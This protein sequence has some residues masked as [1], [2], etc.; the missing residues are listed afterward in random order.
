MIIFHGSL[1]KLKKNLL[2]QK[3]ALHAN[4]ALKK[5]KAAITFIVFV[6]KISV[7]DV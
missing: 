5:L 2:K 4:K 6:V 7:G 1:I 3:N